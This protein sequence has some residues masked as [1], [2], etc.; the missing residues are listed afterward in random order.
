MLKSSFALLKPY[1]YDKS[2]KIFDI[3]NG[4]SGHVETVV[5]LTRVEHS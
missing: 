3:Y 1:D 2:C 4:Y 5:L